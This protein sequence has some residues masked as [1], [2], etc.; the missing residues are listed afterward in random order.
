MRAI[1]SQ[2]TA[3]IARKISHR[4]RP[5]TTV[6]MMTKNMYGSAYSTSTTRIIQAST[7]PPR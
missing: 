4:L 7:R 2:P 5:N 6:R 1:V 3:P